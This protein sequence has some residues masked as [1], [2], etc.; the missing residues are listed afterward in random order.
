MVLTRKVWT[1]TIPLPLEEAWDFFSRPENL[2][3]I[4]PT[5]MKFNL[6]SEL[7]GVTMYPGMLIEYTV[8]PLF[9]VPLSWVTEITHIQDQRYF[10]DEQ[11]HG[12]YR[13]WHHEH[14]FK[15]VEG[16]VE[17]TDLLHYLVPF[18]PI[19]KLLNKVVVEPKIEGIFAF[20]AR[21]IAD[22]F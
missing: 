12:P 1:Q 3:L 4:T 21:Y 20:R 19:G 7:A 11:R 8:S 10:V 6:R 18:G 15:E 17:M 14:H 22:N 9:G 13:L 16:G 2:A 5:E